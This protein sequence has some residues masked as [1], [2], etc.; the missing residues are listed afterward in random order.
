[1]N[2]L[3]LVSLQW[4]VGCG[5]KIISR[6]RFDCG[7]GQKTVPKIGQI[8]R[9]NNSSV[10]FSNKTIHTTFTSQQEDQ[11]R[12]TDQRSPRSAHLSRHTSHSVRLRARLSSRL[13]L[14]SATLFYS[15]SLTRSA[16]CPAAGSGFAS[17]C[18]SGQS[19]DCSAPG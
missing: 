3:N 6:S 1:M 14:R 2:Q 16:D 12:F 4:Q 19:T 5:L 17:C 15:L 11:L 18:S 13:R 7:T 9:L 10:K 8:I